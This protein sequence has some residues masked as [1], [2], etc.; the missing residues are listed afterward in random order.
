MSAADIDAIPNAFPRTLKPPA[1]AEYAG[2]YAT[3]AT[4][5]PF[6]AAGKLASLRTS[7]GDVLVPITVEECGAP[8][9]TYDPRHR[10]IRICYELVA[11]A[12]RLRGKLGD[13]V[14]AADA[15]VRRWLVFVA[16]HEIG[17]ALIDV[18]DLPTTDDTDGEDL[19]D[20]YA[21][22]MLSTSDDARSI[23][24]LFPVVA[25]FAQHGERQGGRSSDRVHRAGAE[26]AL[27]MLCILGARTSRGTPE[28]T[29]FTERITSRWNAMLAPYTRIDTG[30]TF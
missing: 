20:Q 14:Y 24:L 30:N 27:D 19:A 12:N 26:R 6:V 8:N 18:L 4:S 17:H 10:S 21:A 22:L 9:A 3:L 7:L 2:I 11:D 29:A 5:D 28:C 13:E 16:L 25:W 15:V 1:H 23:D